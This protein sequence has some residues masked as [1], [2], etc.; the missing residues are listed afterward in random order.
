MTVASEMGKQRDNA[1]ARPARE[2]GTTQ[3]PTRQRRSADRRRVHREALDVYL[4]ELAAS[5]PL[6]REQEV[7]IA[8]RIEQ[9]QNEAFTAVLES[10]VPLVE[11]PAWLDAVEAETLTATSLNAS[12]KGEAPSEEVLRDR[13]AQAVLY[14]RE[15][16]RAAAG[17]RKGG[18]PKAKQRLLEREV[19]AAILARNSAIREL[20][21][22]R[23]QVDGMITRVADAMRSLA[24]AQERLVLSR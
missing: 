23:S 8:R 16:S 9:A 22:G 24:R 11:L 21:L 3:R 7:R 14:E 5:S 17:L 2:R 15:R 6:T 19:E 1:P 13:L 10:G 12:P 20:D 18:L 4:G